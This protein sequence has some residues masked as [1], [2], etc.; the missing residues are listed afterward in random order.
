MNS[1]GTF[2]RGS[3]PSANLMAISQEPAA[4]KY[5]SD[6]EDVRIS[7]ARGLSLCSADRPQRNTFV[8]SKNFMRSSWHFW[9]AF[10]FG[11][12]IARVRPR[13]TARQNHPGRSSA[14]EKFPKHAAFS[15]EAQEPA[16]PPEHRGSRW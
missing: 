6:D 4:E 8:S 11:L 9:S 13:V 7:C 12:R 16:A 2:G 14:R 3:E 1:E 15:W 5:N 10:S